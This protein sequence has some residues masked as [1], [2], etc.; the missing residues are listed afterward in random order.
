MPKHVDHEQRREEIAAALW[1]LVVRDGIEAASVR[2]VAAE[3]G[4]STGS[5]RHYFQTH[6]QLLTF[7]MELVIQRVTQRVSALRPEGSVQETARRV[8]AEVLPLDADRQAENQVWLAF[9]ARSLVE[10][11]LRALRDEAHAALRGLCLDAVRVLGVAAPEREAERVHA[12]IDGLALH[13]VLDGRVTTPARQLELLTAHL[14]E[15]LQQRAR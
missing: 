6:S 7:A 13:A 4:W 9:T 3:A 12:L 5:L 1:R 11:E 8:L 2:R 10:P 14:D 15:L